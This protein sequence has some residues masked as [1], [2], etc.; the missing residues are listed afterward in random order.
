MFI[1]VMCMLNFYEAIQSSFL[2]SAISM[3]KKYSTVQYS[4]VQYST[5]TIAI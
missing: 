1:W 2:W 5:V 4:T 3:Q